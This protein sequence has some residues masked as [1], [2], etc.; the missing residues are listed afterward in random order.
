MSKNTLNLYVSKAQLSGVQRMDPFHVQC[1]DVVS[2][3][4]QVPEG[5]TAC[6]CD[7][8]ALTQ[9]WKPICDL[10]DCDNQQVVQTNTR[11]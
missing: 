5:R 9:M 6:F 2:T 8:G 4:G 3:F 7:N 1:S 10:T 11:I